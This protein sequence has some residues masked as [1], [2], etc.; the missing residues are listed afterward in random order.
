MYNKTTTHMLMNKVLAVQHEGPNDIDV[1]ITVSL[2]HVSKAELELVIR[3][4]TSL[5][6]GSDTQPDSAL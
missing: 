4:N 6:G 2:G 1:A 5:F 3:V